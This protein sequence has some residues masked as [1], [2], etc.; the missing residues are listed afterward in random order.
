METNKNLM[1]KHNENVVNSINSKRVSR[2]LLHELKELYKM[3]FEEIFLEVTDISNIIILSIREN[4]KDNGKSYR[5][6]FDYDFPFTCPRVFFN[7]HRYNDFLR[8]KTLYENNN[9]K[10]TTGIDCF[11]CS[12]IT[13]QSNWNPVT[14]IS[15][16][17][18]EINYFRKIRRNFAYKVIVKY[19]KKKYL[20]EDIDL[21]CWF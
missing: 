20:I 6:E 1:M 19:I 21:I 10:K 3:N 5:F 7:G 12:S 16:I 9:L 4:L 14:F 8:S 2:R 15:K 13:C 11:C 17:I 18:D